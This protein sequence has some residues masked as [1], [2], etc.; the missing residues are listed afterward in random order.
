MTLWNRFVDSMDQREPATP[1]AL[2]RIAVGLILMW[3]LADI[4]LTGAM[5]CL[6]YPMEAG[7][8]QNPNGNWLWAKLGGPSADN[9]RL[10]YASSLACCLSLIFGLGSRISALVAI[11]LFSALFGL[12]PGSG[13]GHDRL[14]TNAL[15]ILVL[16]P[17]D[18]T[19]SLWSRLKNGH[20]MSLTPVIAWPRYLAIYQLALMYTCTGIQKLGAEWWPMGS[21]LAV[22]YAVLIPYWARADWSTLV[23]MAPWLTQIGSFLTW[24]WE[25]TWWLVLLHFY[26]RKTHTRPG[27]LR[28]LFLKLDLRTIYI[29]IGL[30]MHTTV[31]IMMNLGPFSAITMSYYIC[32]IHH[33]EWVKIG[34]WLK[35]KLSPHPASN[36]SIDPEAKSAR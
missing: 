20:W 30:L 35:R 16:S 26:F 18:T 32:C 2:F 34:L 19:F 12:L 7:G 31:A 10:V 21:Y 17:A 15:W 13:G 23:S 36:L 28:A 25:S 1:L 9:I 11:Q 8:F 6:W 4:G 24:L 27:R 14:I 3:D 5:E 22:Y 29:V 33:D